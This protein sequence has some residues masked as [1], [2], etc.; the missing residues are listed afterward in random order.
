MKKP[1]QKKYAI[2]LIKWVDKY[3]WLH[4]A[5]AT[6]EGTLYKLLWNLRWDMENRF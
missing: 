5:M 3:I 6:R 1:L 4:L 2:T